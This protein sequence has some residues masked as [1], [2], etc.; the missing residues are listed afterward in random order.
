[1]RFKIVLTT[2]QPQTLIPINYAYPLSAVIY[3]ILSLADKEYA[4]FLHDKGYAK[5]DSLKV[6]KLFSCSEIR[7]PFVIQGD[8]LCLQSNQAELFVSFYLP[9]AAEKFIRGLFLYQ[10]LE[11]ADRYSRAEFYISQV[12]ALSPISFSK[13]TS[14]HELLLEPMSPVV[15][16][17]KNAAGHYDFLSPEHPDFARLTLSNWKEKYIAVFGNAD[18]FDTAEL[19]VVLYRNPPK[20]RLITIKA[21]TP[22]QTRIKGFV[23][24]RL[25][26][27]GTQDALE[28]LVEAGA[29]LYNALCFGYVTVASPSPVLY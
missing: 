6:F 26:V 20:P 3:K 5:P 18:L 29:G 12:E 19:A 21:G 9:K 13:Q 7:T 2:Q 15:C 24:F 11:I 4:D 23:N 25:K 8:R 22:A 1:M 27:K 28:L 16:G 10:H 17:F 14:V